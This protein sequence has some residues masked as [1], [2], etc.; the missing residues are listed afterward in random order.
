M[1][2]KIEKKLWP[3]GADFFGQASQFSGMAV[4]QAVEIF[5]AQ[6]G[7]REWAVSVNRYPF[8]QFFKP[9]RDDVDR[10]P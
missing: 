10:W 7:D 1:D 3:G 4:F 6:V 5:E 2:T 9:I 8:L